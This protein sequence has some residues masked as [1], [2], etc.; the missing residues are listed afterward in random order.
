VR[1]NFYRRFGKRFFDVLMTLL[2][3]PILV[4]ASLV[5]A[6]LVR[7]DLGRPV[8]FRQPRP[9]LDGRIFVLSKFRTMTDLRTA[10]GR[11]APDARR[12]SRLGAILR[13][14][15]LD[16]I[17]E[18]W[19]VLTGKMSLVGPRPLLPEYL[20]RYS[21]RQARRHEVRPGITG[22]AQVRGRNALTWEEKL[23]YDVQYVDNLSFALDVSI[24]LATCKVMVSGDGISAP[25]HATM[26]EFD[27][28]RPQGDTDSE[29]DEQRGHP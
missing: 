2:L 7:I 26:P 5:V 22:L 10:A 24:L 9:G 4:P 29:A 3:L 21:P 1:D 18:F 12:I 19:N 11:L 23:E 8:F 25:D 13:R 28:A 14:T 17:P 27:G 20:P 16:E 15:S 6:V